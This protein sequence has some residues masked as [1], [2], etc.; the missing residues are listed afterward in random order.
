MARRLS[1][2]TGVTFRAYT[3]DFGQS[4]LGGGRYD[5]ALLPYAAGFAIG[6]ERLLSAMSGTKGG[7]GPFVLSLDDDASRR[8]RA[9]GYRVERALVTNLDDLKRYARVK[10]IPY[11]LTGEWAR[12]SPGLSR[13]LYEELCALLGVPA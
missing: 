5:G 10:G 1:Y 9:H 6:L 4:L 11:L 3:F 7:A 13:P 2:Y 8:L 12:A